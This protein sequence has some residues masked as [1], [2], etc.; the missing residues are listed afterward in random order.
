MQYQAL[1]ETIFSLGYPGLVPSGGTAQRNGTRSEDESSRSLVPWLVI[2]HSF[3]YSVV[4]TVAV[5]LCSCSCSD[6]YIRNAFKLR[7]YFIGVAY[8]EKI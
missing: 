5:I 4:V 2:V 6:C 7:Q 3:I 8:L 1:K